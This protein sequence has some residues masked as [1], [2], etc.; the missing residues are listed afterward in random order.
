MKKIF[1][2]IIL[3][4]SFLVELKAELPN[5]LINSKSVS[6]FVV[7]LGPNYCFADADNSKAMLGPVLNQSPL[8]NWDISV[9]YRRKF[10]SNLG[11]KVALSFDN[12]TGNDIKSPRNYSFQSNMLQ[13]TVQAEY[14]INFE[15]GCNCK[16]PNS[17][18]GFVGTGVMGSKANLVR[19]GIQDDMSGY[20]YKT[21]DFAP[22]VSLGAGYLYHI[23]N[24]LV[25]GAE[26][27]MEYPF[28]DFIDGFK[29]PFPASNTN[30]FIQ[31]FSVSL[32]FKIF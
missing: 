24:S 5:G 30:D 12:F 15:S 14:S 9:G 32:S 20:Q 6:Y 29:P 18:Y 17:I 1:L 16:T 19:H 22:V 23:T 10:D 25:L 8:K 7:S 2:F 11:Y 21:Y 31:G 3:V 27:K 28:S 4:S 13:L 26:Y